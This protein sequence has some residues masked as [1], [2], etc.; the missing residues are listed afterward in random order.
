MA[1]NLLNQQFESTAPNQIWLTDITYI[2]TEEGWLYVAGHKG[3]FTGEIVGYAMSPRI[4]KNLM[5]QSLF[6]AVAAKRPIPGLIHHSDLGSQYCSQEYRKM[7]DHT[8]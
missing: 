1:E 4:T 6:R 3:I 5:S 8:I 7:L 2:P